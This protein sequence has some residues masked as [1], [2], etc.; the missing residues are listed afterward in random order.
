MLRRVLTPPENFKSF[1][2]DL[3]IKYEESEKNK[4]KNKQKNI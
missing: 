2:E 1:S 4:Q 3:K